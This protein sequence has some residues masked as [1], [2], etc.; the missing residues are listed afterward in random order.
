[1]PKK[2]V[3]MK[4]DITAT[5]RKMQKDGRPIRYITFLYMGA[6]LIVIHNIDSAMLLGL[7]R[8]SLWLYWHVHC[9]LSCHT[10]SIITGEYMSWA[11]CQ[12]TMSCNGHKMGITEKNDSK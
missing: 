2:S 4:L 3:I 9:N 12:N 10:L 11:Y 1:M 6:R 7:H 8:M 5:V